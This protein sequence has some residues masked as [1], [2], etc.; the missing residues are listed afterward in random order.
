MP[1]GRLWVPHRFM[2]KMGKL[3]QRGAVA[4]DFRSYH[5]FLL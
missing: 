1:P 3:Y 2:A 5:H 4:A